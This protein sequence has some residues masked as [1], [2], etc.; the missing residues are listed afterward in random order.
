VKRLVLAL[1]LLLPLGHLSAGTAPPPT[2]PSARPDPKAVTDFSRSL[3]R[4]NST[5]QA[6]DFFRPWAKKN[7]VTRRGLG[8]VVGPNQVLVT[9]ALIANHTF[10]ELER[11]ATSERTP[12][13]VVFADYE[14]NLALL[15]ADDP[16]FLERAVP[17]ALDETA[18]VGSTAEILQLEPNGDIAPTTA[19]LTTITMAQYVLDDVGFLIFRLSAPIQ[20]RDGSFVLPAVRDGRLLGLLMRYDNRNQTADV[21]PPIIISRFLEQAQKEEYAA[22]PRAGIGIAPLRA[23]QLRRYLGLENE[24]G[25]LISRVDPRSSAAAAGIQVDDV[26]LA[27]DDTPI[28]ADGNFN[29][30]EYGRIPLGFLITTN[31]LAGE[32][33]KFHVIRHGEKMEIPVKLRRRDIAGMSVP[34]YLF[35]EQPVYLVRGGLVF[36]E[37]TRAFLQE[38]GPEWRNNAP[39]RL[40]AADLFQDDLRPGGERV[41]FL[42]SV[43][44]T[45]ATLG[46]ENLSGLIVDK[47]DGRPI[48]SLRDVD[49]A[50]RESMVPIHRIEVSDD[51]RLLFL[52]RAAADEVESSIARQFGIPQLSHLGPEDSAEVVVPVLLPASPV[53]EKET[54]LPTPE[55]E[56]PPPAE[57]IIPDPPGTEESPLVE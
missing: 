6:Y 46:Y 26:L 3:I 24:A 27:I 44:P 31:R 18:R 33:V 10:I 22:F 29:H 42:A 11:P 36:L 5:T 16:A 2:I 9:A 35:D 54:T 57:D 56:P 32:V 38:W 19:R 53:V 39:Q 41:V 8:T 50:F 34:L 23:P 17:L 37:L 7:P 13:R 40:V 14:A 45:P 49:R 48:H 52:D 55:Q 47:I 12:A 21:I 30:P 51:P 20:Q 25:V 43:L 15:A 4:V 1:A 28:D